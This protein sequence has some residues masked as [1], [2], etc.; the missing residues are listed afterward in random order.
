MG[1][2]V[3]NAELTTEARATA[4]SSIRNYA[5]S[6]YA[7]NTLGVPDIKLLN[8]DGSSFTVGAT[9][10]DATKVV[11]LK[12]EPGSSASEDR[13]PNQTVSKKS[14]P[15]LSYPPSKCTLL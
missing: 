10:K 9:N 3:K 4:T 11:V 13:R 8:S 7:T 6:A 2:V 15:I 1:V 12:V 5:L 14:E